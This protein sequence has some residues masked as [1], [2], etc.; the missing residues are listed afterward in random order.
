MQLHPHFLF[1]TL[2]AISTL[3]HEDAKAADHM[4]T[5]LSDLLRL[6]LDSAG[7]Q[8]VSLKQEL[9]FLTPYLE[10]EQ[11]RFQDRLSVQLDIEPETLDAAVPNL[12]CS[13]SSRTRSITGSRRSPPRPH[14]HPRAEAKRSAPGRGGRQRPR[15]AAGVDRVSRGRRLG[16]PGAAAATLR[17]HHRFQ[18]KDADGCGLRVTFEIPHGRT[19]P[20]LIGT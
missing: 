2:H 18:L 8:E 14:R 15:A 12:S 4:I 19:M 7:R 13:R 10:I 20:R 5:R 11:A 6:T 17:N 3:V 1:N 16:T 9:E